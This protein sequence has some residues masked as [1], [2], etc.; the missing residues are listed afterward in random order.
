MSFGLVYSNTAEA[1]CPDG[2][3]SVTV[4]LQDSYGDGNGG[5]GYIDDAVTNPIDPEPDDFGSLWTTEVCLAPGAHTFYFDQSTEQ[6]EG[7]FSWFGELTYAVKDTANGEI[8]TSGNPGIAIISDTFEV[9]AVGGCTNASATNFNGAANFNDGSCICAS[10]TE[11]AVSIG[12]TDNFDGNSGS[13]R[14]LTATGEVIASIPGVAGTTNGATNT[15][16]NNISLCPGSYD[17]VFESDN[18]AGTL[19]LSTEIKVGETL[20]AS[21]ACNGA[22]GNLRTIMI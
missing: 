15:A 19:Q 7:V 21:G 16:V 22:D 13:G 9:V 18:E 8:L 20:L 10:G 14:V 17:F 3:I 6:I 12:S 11:T 4:E 1:S 2:S 5:N